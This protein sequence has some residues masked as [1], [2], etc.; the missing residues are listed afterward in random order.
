M[1][2]A[3]AFCQ[4]QNI[5]YSRTP[6]QRSL[7]QM[8]SFELSKIPEYKTQF[9]TIDWFK[10]IEEII[11][12]TD[13]YQLTYRYGWKH[14]DDHFVKESVHADICRVSSEFFKK[15]N[16]IAIKQTN[17]IRCDKVFRKYHSGLMVCYDSKALFPSMTYWELMSVKSRY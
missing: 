10:G 1:D 6:I 16:S 15:I 17:S 9:R 14:R 11:V 5:L 3:E 2:D 7:E 13:G 8:I 4:K 12:E